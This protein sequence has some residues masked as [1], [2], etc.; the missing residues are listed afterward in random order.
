MENTVTPLR[1]A[2]L[3]YGR[4]GKEVEKIALERGHEIVCRIDSEPDFEAHAE[5]WRTADVAIEF[6]VPAAVVSHM[7]R[8]LEVGMP[9]VAGTTA[10]QQEEARLRKRGVL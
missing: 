8:C 5:A 7:E 3:G 2:L 4:M 9:I 1:I 6:S 10:W